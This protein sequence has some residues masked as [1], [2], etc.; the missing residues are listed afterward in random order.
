MA[1]GAIF[2]SADGAHTSPHATAHADFL[3]DAALDLGDQVLVLF[4]PQQICPAFQPAVSVSGCRH[5]GFFPHHLR[6]V[7]A[8][9]LPLGGPLMVEDTALAHKQL[10]Q[11]LQR[12]RIKAFKVP[13]HLVVAQPHAEHV[14]LFLR[15]RRL[16]KLIDVR[17][18]FPNLHLTPPVFRFSQRWLTP[19]LCRSPFSTSVPAPG[20]GPPSLPPPDPAN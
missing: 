4:R 5:H 7:N 10:A 16:G 8:G 14:N 11:P 17:Q 12:R 1:A 2:R 15:Q 3:F 6:T 19:P 13:V 18:F 20:R 9:R